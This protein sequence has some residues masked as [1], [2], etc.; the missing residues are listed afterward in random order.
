[1]ALADNLVA[2][3]ELEEASGT[4]VDSHASYDLTDSGSPTN[5]TGIQGN[6][7]DLELSS[8][9][10]LYVADPFHISDNLSISSWIKAESFTNS[11]NRWI[12]KWYNQNEY[13]LRLNAGK[14]NVLMSCSGGTVQVTGASSLYTST[15]YHIVVTY[16]STDGLKVYVN[17]GSPL[18]ASANG[19]INNSVEPFTIGVARSDGG[20][21]STGTLFDGIVDEVGVWDRTLTADDVAELY[22]SG[23]GM[24]YAD[25]T[26]GGGSPTNTT[27]FFLMM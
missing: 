19:T 1:M 9:Q 15:W 16:N 13:I 12:C 6:G 25:I 7:V 27:N 23:A 5:A 8:S 20:A 17:N 22:N 18:T 11:D 26:G 10:Y 3:W 21:I 14:V 2:Y 4:R 24:S